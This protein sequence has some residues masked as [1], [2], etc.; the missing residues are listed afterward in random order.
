VEGEDCFGVP[1]HRSVGMLL[2]LGVL[3]LRF[4]GTLLLLI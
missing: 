2:F 1:N 4:T 3:S